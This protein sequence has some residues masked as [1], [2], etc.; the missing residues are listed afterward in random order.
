M[1][2]YLDDQTFATALQP[3]QTVRA[4]VDEVRASLRGTD[5][6]VMGI[7]ADGL[8]VTDEGYEEMLTGPVESFGRYDFSSADPRQV[9]GTAL[10][11]CLDLLS[12][13]DAHRVQAIAAFTRGDAGQGLESLG[14][15]CRAWQQIH[16]GIANAIR[17][18]GLDPQARS[19]SES[20]LLAALSGVRAL[21]EQVREALQARDF[22]LVSDILQYEFD[23]LIENWGTLIH[24]IL[25]T[26]EHPTHEREPAV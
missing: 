18:L 16:D 1:L 24:T 5:R 10:S 21:L 12:A 2:V 4:L 11:E 13:N 9:V 17:L 23:P 19:L 14:E 25:E 7:R 15:C 3:G 8:D 22:V 6:L 26:V 20:S